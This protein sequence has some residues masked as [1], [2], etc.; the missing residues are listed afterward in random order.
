[1]EAN[2]DGSLE[3]APLLVVEVLSP[4]NRVAEI[5]YQVRAYLESDLEEVIVVKRDGEV[6]YHRED[7]EHSRSDVGVKLNLP[8]EL[9]E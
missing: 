6:V 2:V 5:S 3:A 9:F 4:S 7:G 8:A 1:M